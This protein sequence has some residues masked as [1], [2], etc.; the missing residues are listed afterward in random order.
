[1]D[2]TILIPGTRGYKTAMHQK[3]K[4]SITGNKTIGKHVCR[5][6][7][8]YIGLIEKTQRN[9]KNES[10]MLIKGNIQQ[11]TQCHF[12]FMNSVY[13]FSELM[14][15]YLCNLNNTFINRITHLN[16]V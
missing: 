3:S 9:A 12:M 13:F 7:T 8:S 10:L 16:M 11:T 1:M 14:K 15:L 2:S 6:K 4:R 5:T